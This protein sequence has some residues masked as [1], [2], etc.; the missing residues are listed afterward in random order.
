VNIRDVTKLTNNIHAGIKYMRF[1]R[2][3]YL[4]DA[5]TMSDIDRHLFA[6]ASYNA[7]PNRIAAM[8]RRAAAQGLNPNVWFQNVE[9]LAAKEIGR[10][11]VQYV[12]NIFKY[13]VAYKLALEKE[14]Q[15]K[16]AR[17]RNTRNTRG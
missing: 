15:R 5:P 9:V 2:D 3:K 16:A 17:G 1:I 11:T 7:G 10:E 4:S 14:S 12:S 13:Y 6:F 8:R